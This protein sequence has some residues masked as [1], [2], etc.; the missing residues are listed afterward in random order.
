MSKRGTDAMKYVLIIPED[1]Q[2]VLREHL[3]QNEL[4]QG[5]FLFAHIVNS[6]KKFGLEATDIYLVP[7]H[8]WQVQLDIHLEMKDSERARI[9]NIART[10]GLAVIDC[11]SHPNSNDAVW[12]SPSDYLGITEFASY[13]K[14]KLEGRPYAAMVWGT[15]SVDAV[16]WYDTFT[17]A[18]QVDE[19][20]IVGNSTEIMIPKR[21]WFKSKKLVWQGQLY[22]NS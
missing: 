7:P 21:T 12:F 14:W 13:A 2:R 11:H 4:E 1:I 3:F 16:I 6:S 9:M 22:D 15:S 10:R 19:V 18:Y 5:A 17:E 8:G 20:S